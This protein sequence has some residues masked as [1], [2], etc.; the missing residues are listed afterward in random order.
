MSIEDSE[1]KLNDQ[2]GCNECDPEG[3]GW[4]INVEL[5]KK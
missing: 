4:G 3:I 2:A 1:K 5:I